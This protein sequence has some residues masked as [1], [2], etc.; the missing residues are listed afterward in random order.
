VGDVG[1][2]ELDG[3]GKPSPDDPH[4]LARDG[5]TPWIVEQDGLEKS[6]GE[7]AFPGPAFARA[8][9]EGSAEMDVEIYNIADADLAPDPRLGLRPTRPR[10][11]LTG[12]A[13]ERR[14][15]VS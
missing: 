13:R 2:F 7:P 8:R 4:A 5:A 15:G 6:G 9:V 14:R 3:I 10:L 1:F 12:V 11:D